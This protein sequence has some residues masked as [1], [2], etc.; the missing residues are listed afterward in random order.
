MASNLLTLNL[1]NFTH[2]QQKLC[3][4]LVSQKINRAVKLTEED[5]SFFIQYLSLPQQTETLY[6]TFDEKSEGGIAVTLNTYKSS[7]NDN[8]PCW[9]NSFLK[10]YYTHFILQYFRSLKLPVKLNFVGDIE[11]WVPDKSPYIQCDGFRVFQ[12]R[13]QLEGVT[14]KP[15]LIVSSGGVTSVYKE[16]VTSRL[17]KELS[18]DDFNWVL[19]ENRLYRYTEMSDNARR[20]LDQ[21][22]PCV[23]KKLQ[24]ALGIPQPAPD[25]SNKYIRYWNEISVFKDRFL[26]TTGFRKFMEFES[27]EWTIVPSKRL[28]ES[29]L[30][31]SS[32]LFGHGGV[33]TDP[34][35][36]I[37]KFAPKELFKQDV[38]VV[39]FFIC[40]NADKL[41]AKTV[42]D[43]LMGD[44]QGFSG[45]AKFV[46][47]NYLTE[48]GWSIYFDNKEN[49][50][51]E[52][53]A[54]LNERKIDPDKRYVA[55][56][57]SP[58]SKWSESEENKA[59]YYRVKEE[60]LHRGIVSQVI[61]VEKTWGS[62]RIE[63][64]NKAVLAESFIFSLP[65]IA[66]ALLAKL[67][68]TPWSL[69]H[70]DTNELII[71]ISAFNCDT[72]DKKYLGSA[73]SFS[74]EGKF[75][76]FDCFRKD[77]IS[78]L[79]G[80]ILMAVKEYCLEHK[81]LQRLII[82]FYK[83]LSKDELKPIE[84]G[85]AELGLDIPVIVISMNKTLSEDVL[86]FDLSQST[87]MPNTGTYLP[88][89]HEQYLLYNNG[90]IEGKTYNAREGYPFPIK[91]SI[92]K[93]PSK[94]LESNPIEDTTVP[95]LLHQ[96]CQFSQLYWKSVSKQSLPV[97]LKYSE[98]L[99]QIVPH[100]IHSELPQT[101]KETLW[102]L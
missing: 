52:I 90:H 12:L 95:E 71:G 9:S 2:N 75:Y 61:E 89:G 72:N 38:H 69:K 48:K 46:N 15:G 31:E 54:Q 34:Y 59:I 101:G 62:Y 27:T 21:V 4:Y 7:D 57:L 102:F 19:F 13:V 97:T 36:G 47:I 43:Y 42:H 23:N 41:M 92:K 14:E 63:E 37:K 68:G 84:K 73:F 67:G 99:A 53:V 74:N 55:I 60:L 56:Y 81:T 98:M 91:L 25:K 17:L 44:K 93:Y 33:D 24:K 3:C 45:I 35:T 88:I 65:N 10:Q 6:T 96:I 66:I 87:L 18:H 16:P 40:Q 64:N 20:N 28:D 22:F 32:L 8:E 76:G 80:S 79:A 5:T 77:Q 50:L 11:V 1:L 51:P 94:S 49:P 29:Q 100:F 78:E 30:K 86:G 83:T 70:N 82:H 39:F 85:L 26:L 58:F